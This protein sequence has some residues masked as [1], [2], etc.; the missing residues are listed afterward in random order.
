M[1]TRTAGEPVAAWG[2]SEVLD[3]VAPA[4]QGAAECEG[5]WLPKSYLAI[6]AAGGEGTVLGPRHAQGSA[7]MCQ[8]AVDE[9]TGAN[10]GQ[11]KFSGCSDS[12][13]LCVVW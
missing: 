2:P 8:L 12:G 13:E 10:I 11:A 9:R 7:A 1:S 5:D 6:L 4:L 3:P